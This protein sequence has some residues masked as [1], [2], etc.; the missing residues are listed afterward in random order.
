MRITV[1]PV[2]TKLTP[3]MVR[4]MFELRARGWTQRLLGDRFGVNRTAVSRALTGKRW[5]D[6]RAASRIHPRSCRTPRRSVRPEQS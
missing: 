2:R 3:K 4:E 1:R 5:S 6:V